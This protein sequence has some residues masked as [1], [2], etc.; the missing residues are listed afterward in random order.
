MFVYMTQTGGA[1]IVA[2]AAMTALVVAYIF[3]RLGA[4]RDYLPDHPN[5]RSSHRRV[6]PRSGGLAI[7]AG[8]LLAMMIIASFVGAASV[9]AEILKI[10]AL[11]GLVLLIGFADDRF[12]MTP[13]FKFAGQ[14]AAAAVF[15]WL[16]GGL[17]SAPMPFAGDTA[18]GFWG[19][20]LTIFW[21]SGFMNAFN[22]M[23][24]ANGIA[25]ST[26]V[27]ALCALSIGCASLGAPLVAIVSIV[28]A[29]S[30]AGFLRINFPSGRIFMGDN[31]SQTVSFLIAVLAVMAT[32]NTGGALSALF[33]P[34]MMMPFLF[35]VTFTLMHRLRRG[36]N[37]LS[38]HREHVYQ[39]LLRH[40]ASHVRVTSIYIILTAFSTAVAIMMLRLSPGMQWAAP[41]A[42]ALLFLFPA[43]SLYR[44]S[45]A[46]GFFGDAEK[47]EE[48]ED[49]FLGDLLE[50]KPTPQ[51]AE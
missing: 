5:Y 46:A 43:A 20:L 1:I 40:G 18:L 47:E 27:I 44:L 29:F 13:L 10:S 36:E 49:E 50:V 41:A 37:I 16:I 3:S 12:S 39:L 9:A 7:I 11:G 24:G 19:V 22:F 51:A 32:N 14:A 17:Q 8:W 35:D 28:L 30:V 45:K 33:V 25:G 42:L 15:V 4:N 2:A 6:T 34:T 38:A 21:I 48:D 23:D 31:G 26:A